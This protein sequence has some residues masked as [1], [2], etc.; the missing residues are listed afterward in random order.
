[1]F[2]H[3]PLPRDDLGRLGYLLR[4]LG[5]LGAATTRTARRRRMNNAP[6][7]QIGRKA[8]PRRLAP[9]EAPH[10]DARRFCLGLVLSQCCGQLLQLQFQLIDEPLAALGARTELLAL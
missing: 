2:G 7:R 9:R 6:T 4:D 8:A 1:M 3:E 10:L 5:E